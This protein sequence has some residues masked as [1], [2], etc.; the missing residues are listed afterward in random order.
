MDDR[1]RLALYP[2]VVVRT[3]CRVGSRAGTTDWRGWPRNSGRR[4][5]CATSSIGFPMTARGARRRV[6]SVAFQSAA[7]TC[8]TSSSLG[9]PGSCDSGS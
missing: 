5:V 6:A 9:R 4:S 7:S 2:Y 3:P 1:D 8:R